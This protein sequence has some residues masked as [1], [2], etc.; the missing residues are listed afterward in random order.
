MV[1][2]VS[3][4][5][6]TK[7]GADAAKNNRVRSVCTRLNKIRQ[8]NDAVVKYDLIN[9][10]IKTIIDAAPQFRIT[11]H[12]IRYMQAKLAKEDEQNVVSP[13]CNQQNGPESLLSSSSFRKPGG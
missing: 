1:S 2:I 9:K 12:N 13:G 4:R 8:E 7:Q 3:I 5:R 10:L 6:D 11:R